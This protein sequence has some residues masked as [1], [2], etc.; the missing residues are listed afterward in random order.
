MRLISI[1][2]LVAGAAGIS[3]AQLSPEESASR[4][5]PLTTARAL[6]QAALS[7]AQSG[8]RVKA[9]DT[10][11][12][13]L[14]QGANDPVI[15]GN[16]ANLLLLEGRFTD[17]VRAYDVLLQGNELQHYALYLNRS[18]ALRALGDYLGAQ[19]DYQDYLRARSVTA[20]LPRTVESGADPAPSE[21]HKRSSEH[22]PQPRPLKR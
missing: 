7:Q 1:V 14:S 17:S 5:E 10:M 8:E 19:R 21:P 22:V 13:A 2:L 4:L 20:Q 9:R 3:A 12:E 6:S 15:I 16:N 11:N 18:L